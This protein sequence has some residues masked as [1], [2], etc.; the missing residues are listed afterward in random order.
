M[1]CLTCGSDQQGQFM[2]IRKRFDE[3][4]RSLDSCREQDTLSTFLVFTIQFGLL[5]I[6]GEVERMGT[7]TSA[8]ERSPLRND[9]VFPPIL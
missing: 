8:M 7:S 5:G 6:F 4:S 2:H 3:P 9:A 1:K